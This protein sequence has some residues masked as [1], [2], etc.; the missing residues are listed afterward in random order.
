MY[1]LNFL[2]KWQ[3]AVNEIPVNKNSK[4]FIDGNLIQSKLPFRKKIKFILYNIQYKANTAV[5]GFFDDFES[6]ITR[7]L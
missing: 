7:D 1:V 2:A 4:V 5:L 6:L 3:L